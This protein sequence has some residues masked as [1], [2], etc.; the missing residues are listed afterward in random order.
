MKTRTR[1]NRAALC[2]FFG[3]TCL[4]AGNALAVPNQ[5]AEIRELRMLID[6]LRRQNEALSRRLERLERG[7]ADRN[8][9]IQAQERKLEK[10]AEL[11]S[12]FEKALEKIGDRVSIHGS[13][14][15]ELRFLGEYGGERTSEIAIDTVDVELGV[16]LTEWARALALFK[17][18]ENDAYVDEAYLTLGKTD[19]MPFFL[20]VGR[21]VA[22]FGDNSGN[23]VQ[24]PFTQSLGE[25][26]GGAGVIGY[27]GGGFTAAVF[28]YNGV[29]ETGDDER[30]NGVGAAAGYEREWENGFFFGVGA[31]IVNNIASAD[32]IE[33]MLPLTDDGET[34]L[35][36]MVAGFNLHADAGFGSFWAIAEYT[37]A[38]G[39]FHA[40]DLAFGG[41]GARPAALNVELAYI[42]E[43]AGHETTFAVGFQKTWESAA[44]YLPEF[45]YSA[46][47]AVTLAD[48][49][50]LTVEGFI[51]KD[52]DEADDGTGDHGNGFT[53]QL[54]YD[55]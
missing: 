42:T 31:G 6:A 22:P 17:V 46:S 54:S 3:A 35:T 38:L 9:R 52:Y 12:G 51:D 4:G 28:A 15:A 40:D 7:E 50:T 13:I 8:A 2:L 48:G 47:V 39:G 18:D 32:G 33:G 36:D 16:K 11:T 41:R 5:E 20:R 55:F 10:Q 14:D 30:I 1:L 21:L 49:L 25:I 26:I 29:D 53:T 27:D 23:M 37:T 43:I 19:D 45:R 24:D 34:R 44:L